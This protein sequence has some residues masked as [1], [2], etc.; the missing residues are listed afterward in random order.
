MK[1]QEEAPE[2]LT[3]LGVASRDTLGA[4]GSQMEA[5]GLRAMAGIRD[6]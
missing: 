2:G 6:D 5:Q 3:A 4:I 1:P